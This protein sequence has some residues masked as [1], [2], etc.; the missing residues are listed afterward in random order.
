MMSSKNKMATRTAKG[1]PIEQ[2]KREDG[3]HDHKQNTMASRTASR[4]VGRTR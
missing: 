2:K 1:L 4:I 3:K